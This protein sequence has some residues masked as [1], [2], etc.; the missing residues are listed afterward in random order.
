MNN[1]RTNKL[2]AFTARVRAHA[3]YKATAVLRRFLKIFAVVVFIVSVLSLHS[4]RI[5]NL[6][7]AFGGKRAPPAVL[8]MIC[9]KNC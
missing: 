8:K 2:S 4:P 1:K 7:T 9:G 6:K 5:W 3:F